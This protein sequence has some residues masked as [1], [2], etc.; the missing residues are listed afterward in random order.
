MGLKS[1]KDLFDAPAATWDVVF[2]MT[3]K[4]LCHFGVRGLFFF[5]RGDQIV[6]RIAVDQFVIGIDARKCRFFIDNKR[7][8]RTVRLEPLLFQEVSDVLSC[9]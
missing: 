7:H 1:C 5:F 3:H 6:F 9:R 2:A 4:Y 8:R